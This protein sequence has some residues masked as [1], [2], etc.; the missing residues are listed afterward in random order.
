MAQQPPEGQLTPSLPTMLPT[1]FLSNPKAFLQSVGPF[2]VL[3]EQEHCLGKTSVPL[4]DK[5]KPLWGKIPI[6]DP[7]GIPS[8]GGSNQNPSAC[9]RAWGQQKGCVPGLGPL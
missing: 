9:S 6:P 8:A 7:K 4:L 2:Q 5:A 1:A 3:G